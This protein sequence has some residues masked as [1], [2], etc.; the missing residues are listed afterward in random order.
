MRVLSCWSLF[1][2]FALTIT[3]QGC[4]TERVFPRQECGEVLCKLDERCSTEGVCIPNL[5]PIQPALDLGPQ[6]PIFDGFLPDSSLDEGLDFDSSD[7]DLT[8]LDVDEG[9][10]IDGMDPPPDLCPIVGL[11]ATEFTLSPGEVLTLDPIVMDPVD[12]PTLSYAWTVIQRPSNSSAQIIESLNVEGRPNEGGVPD[13]QSTPAAL[14]IPDLIGEYTF[15]LTLITENGTEVPSELCP[16]DPVR[17]SLSAEIQQAFYF[18]L[19]WTTPNDPD[20]SD[21]NGSDL[22]LH[23]RHANAGGW[24]D[25]SYDCYFGNR[26]P[27]WGETGPVD[28]PSLDIIDDNGEGP[29]VISIDEYNFQTL[30]TLTIGVHYYNS[31]VFGAGDFGASNAFVKAYIGGVRLGEWDE[32]LEQT[33]AFW[34][35]F[36]IIPDLDSESEYDTFTIDHINRV[37]ESILDAD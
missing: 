30:P 23:L 22:D 4:I 16:Q 19:V 6:P 20:P 37:Y 32:Q 34:T 17:L 5:D 2:G 8:D 26:Y 11:A 33:D 13:D 35:V 18:E 9:L 28:N 27:D 3:L 15:E 36:S 24:T 31:G 21:Q 25:P 1:Y 12:N 7:S 14:F 10:V 29:E